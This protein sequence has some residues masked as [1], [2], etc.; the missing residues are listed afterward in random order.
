M[1]AAIAKANAEGGVNGYHI[2]VKLY[3]AQSTP[4]GGLTAARQAIA[5]HDFAVLA[6]SAGLQGGLP[7][8]NSA[9]LPTIGD[10]DVPA[11]SNAPYLFSVSGNILT[12]NTSAWMQVLINEGRTKIAIPGGT[13]NPVAA[14]NWE[15]L[16][17]FA[18]GQ[19]CF[20]RVGIDGT[21]TAA[22]TALAHEIISA[23]CQGVA[24]PTLYPGTLQ[25]QI[26]LNALGGNV[27]VVDAADGGPAVIQQ[28]GSS[29][30]NLIF[31]NQIASP[32]ATADPGIQEFDATVQKYEPGASIYC[33]V[34]EK[35][36]ASVKWF[37][38][39]LGQVQGTPTQA[40]L[41]TA[42]DSTNGYN[43]NGLV[44]PIT[45][46]AFHTVG[47]LCLSYSV[48]KNAKWVPLID[49]PSPFLCGKRF[50]G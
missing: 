4:S 32:Y 43:A 49:G 31:A 27:Q 8:L 41:V 15:H 12:Q 21:N 30:N 23:G 14:T 42:L 18:G 44:G 13:I 39:A 33:G 48:I 5:D 2:N 26:A 19:L 1:L 46:P 37:L 38:N 28:A 24:S 7:T 50:A 9:K 47:T 34:C 45:E 17:P 36:Y 40:A 6:D 10:G 25:L 22:I 20:G 29:A 16:V 11:W 3:D 35:G